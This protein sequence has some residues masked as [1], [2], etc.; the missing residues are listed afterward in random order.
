[1]EIN[2]TNSDSY[3]PKPKKWADAI[4]TKHISKHDGWYCL[5]NTILKTLEYPLM[6]TTMTRKQCNALM[7]P[8]LKAGLPKSQVQCS[9][10]RAIVHGSLSVQGFDLHHLHSTQTIQH[11]QALMRHGTR[12][13]HHRSTPPSHHAGTSIGTGICSVF[14]ALGFPHLEFPCHSLLDL[15]PLGKPSSSLPWIFVDLPLL[16]PLPELV[17]LV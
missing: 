15:P 2:P 13:H 5:N 3:S 11:L 12:N 14:L 9:M 10:P 8:I 17:T 4:R 7:T 16:P 6:A 1:M